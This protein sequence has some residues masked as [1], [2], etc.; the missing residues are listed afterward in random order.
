MWQ[1]SNPVVTEALV[2][3]TWGGPQ[4]I[5]N[6]GLQQARV[7]YYDADARRPGLPPNIAALVSSIDPQ[8]TVVDLV[9]LDPRTPR[10]LI[11]QAGAFAEH[12]IRAVTYTTCEDPSWIGD[13]YDYGH[14]QPTVNSQ[15]MNVADP[16][17]AVDLPRSCTVR[18]TLRLDLRTNQP[19]YRS[20]FD[21]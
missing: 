1:Q 12:T 18:L 15:S 14:G 16:W 3:L 21:A 10:R 20:P 9:N 19:S 13:L 4:V 5:Y 7:R 8:A 6:G 17:L 11:V 2:Q